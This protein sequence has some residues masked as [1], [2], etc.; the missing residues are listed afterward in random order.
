[1]TQPFDPVWR[2]QEP[3]DE[4]EDAIEAADGLPEDGEEKGHPTTATD[5]SVLI[6]KEV[7]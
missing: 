7:A 1:M 5:V 6:A 2:E 4:Y 3:T